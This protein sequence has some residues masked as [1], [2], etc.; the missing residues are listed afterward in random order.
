MLLN[1]CTYLIVYYDLITI[2]FTLQLS[3]IG[4]NVF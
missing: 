4:L 2:F 1:K 3:N